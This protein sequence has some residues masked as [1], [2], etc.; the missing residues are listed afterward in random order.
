MII[1]VMGKEEQMEKMEEK[2]AR[3][4]EKHG[5]EFTEK[6][7]ALLLDEN[8]ELRMCTVCGRFM[9]K[10]MINEVSPYEYY[11]SEDCTRKVMS[12]RDALL[13][14][15][16]VEPGSYPEKT[17]EEIEAMAERDDGGLATLYYTEWFIPDELIAKLNRLQ[18]A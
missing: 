10:G 12:R 2:L 15:I 5:D 1:E 8:S 3:I 17:D 11:C 4:L 7:K 9:N 13:L 14:Y 16:G 6:E 18:E